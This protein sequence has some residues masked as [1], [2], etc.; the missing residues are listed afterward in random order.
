MTDPHA[1]ARL[2][3]SLREEVARAV[4]GGEEP[5]RL[6]T[7]ALLAEGH[8][9]IEDVPALLS[10]PHADSV[11]AAIAVAESVVPSVLPMLLSFTYPTFG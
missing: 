11:S 1:G 4:V 9:L 6:L 2:W 8:A 3:R 5:L 7:V 10:L